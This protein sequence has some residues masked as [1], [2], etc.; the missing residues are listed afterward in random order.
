MKP[1]TMV[2]TRRIQLVLC[3]QFLTGF[4]FGMGYRN[5]VAKAIV[6]QQSCSLVDT[7]FFYKR[8][9]WGLIAQCLENG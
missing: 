4:L 9:G 5:K 3:F 1:V 6:E 7:E 2:H 8:Q